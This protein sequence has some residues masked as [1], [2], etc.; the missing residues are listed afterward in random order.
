[1]GSKDSLA[2]FIRK[3]REKEDGSNWGI[4][5]MDTALNERQSRGRK[6]MWLLDQ[7]TGTVEGQTD[8]PVANATVYSVGYSKY[9]RGRSIRP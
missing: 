1:M 5:I 8:S 6:P 9:G 3:A 7:I 4:A 2:Q